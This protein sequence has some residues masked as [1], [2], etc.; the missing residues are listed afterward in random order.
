[1]SSSPG[2]PSTG[3]DSKREPQTV[4]ETVPSD[5]CEETG[6]RSALSK[7]RLSSRSM[8]TVDMLRHV[9][10]VGTWAIP[11]MMFGTFIAAIAVTVVHHIFLSTLNGKRVEDY[12]L[13]QSLVRDIGNALSHIVQIL[14]ETSVGAA[15][16]QSIWF[17][18]RRHT[19]RLSE[20]DSLFSLPSIFSIAS[21]PAAFG[22]V[23]VLMI[24]ICIQ[25]FSFIT[26]LAPSALSVTPSG[27]TQGTMRVPVPRLDEVPLTDSI[28]PVVNCHTTSDPGDPSQCTDYD[29][30]YTS[31]SPAFRRM[32]QNVLGNL[33][34]PS[35]S[36]PDECGLACNY[37]ITY[38][39]PA[40]RC[41]D[42]PASTI[43]SGVANFPEGG[44]RPDPPYGNV[45]NPEGTLLQGY[46]FNAS[47]SSTLGSLYAADCG[48]GSTT[49]VDCYPPYYLSLPSWQDTDPYTLSIVYTADALNPHSAT[50]PA[51]GA[52]CV[53]TSAT[54]QASISYTHDSQTRTARVVDH[55]EPYSSLVRA[56]I[57]TGNLTAMGPDVQSAYAALGIMD[58]IAHSLV[59]TVLVGNIGTL[60][61]SATGV[62]DSNLFQVRSENNVTV[63]E[64][65]STSYLSL[66]AGYNNLSQALEDLCTNVTASLMSDTT[67][68]GIYTTVSGTVLPDQNVYSYQLLR[69]WLVYGVAV[70]AAL[71]A[72][73]FGLACIRSNGGAM[74]RTFSTIAASARD[75]ELDELL[76]GPDEALPP[77]AQDAKLR[78]HSNVVVNEGRA[79]F[80]VL[81]GR[82]GGV[83]RAMTE[84]RTVT[85]TPE[86]TP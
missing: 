2:T 20:L 16:T 43:A 79:G 31:A 71:L 85:R 17:F 22:T 68:L 8:S 46:A 59:G 13:S 51:T 27:P 12:A 1:M 39:G 36:R 64:P 54:Y 9:R 24:V 47:C 48:I 52:S 34:I 7:S 21:V 35:W 38:N 56:N 15:L 26:I 58:A 77:A 62:L 57:T 18:V 32:V 10:R 69:L 75:T 55:G 61:P 84:L 40:L 81:Q 30:I 60:L 42:I 49:N 33:E 50:H 86:F 63:D 82:G 70:L 37:T 78:Y 19:V 41:T 29:L 73:M 45:S 44:A 65:Y 72:D 53:F 25:A 28:T 83:E 6:R 11:V 67:D 66:N 80:K 76:N 4:Y 14:L 5:D 3:G 23:Y 74:L